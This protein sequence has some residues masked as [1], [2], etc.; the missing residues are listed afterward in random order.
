MKGIAVAS[1]LVLSSLTLAAQ[2]GGT[3]YAVAGPESLAQNLNDSNQARRQF[4]LQNPERFKLQDLRQ[5]VGAVPACPIGMRA[6]QGVWDHTMKVRNF[7][8]EIT[9]APFGQRI[10]LT[11]IDARPA[12][13]VSAT[14]LVRGLNGKNHMVKTA[15]ARSGPNAARTLHVT[16][17]KG[18]DN[19]VSADLY[20]PGFTSVSSVQLQQVT[21]ADGSTWRTSGTKFCRVTPDPMMLIA[22]H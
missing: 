5:M 13:I 3:S 6:S 14:V 22:E 10:L 21:Y 11:L 19:D 15:D 9:K 1:L 16:F 18:Q 4:K 2:S 12:N 20:V 7:D 8:R 17:T